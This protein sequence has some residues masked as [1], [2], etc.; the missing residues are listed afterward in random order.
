MNEA[1]LGKV[2]QNDVV[3]PND[4]NKILLHNEASDSC[5]INQLSIHVVKAELK[6]TELP[7]EELLTDLELEEFK[8]NPE[9]ELQL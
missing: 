1:K 2:E 8:L 7:M 6:A 5:R 3:E 4:E 9:S